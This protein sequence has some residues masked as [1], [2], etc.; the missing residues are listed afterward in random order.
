MPTV[1]VGRNVPSRCAAGIGHLGW[2][3]WPTPVIETGVPDSLP[4][5]SPNAKSWFASSGGE[6]RIV[7]LIG[8]A[9]SI[10]T[11]EKWQLAPISAPHPLRAAFIDGLCQQNPNMPPL[12]GQP[13]SSQQAYSA[14]EVYVKPNQV[15]GDSLVLPFLEVYD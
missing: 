8:I 15:V 6:V 7:L 4:R 3:T 14:Q 9:R 11:F 1:C 12:I 5:L 13:A 2:S 10:I